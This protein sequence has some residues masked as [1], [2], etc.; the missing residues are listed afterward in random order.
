M[1]R[2]RKKPVLSAIDWQ[3]LLDCGCRVVTRKKFAPHC[4]PC[5]EHGRQWVMTYHDP[6]RGHDVVVNG[7]EVRTLE[8]DHGRMSIRFAH[9]PKL[10]GDVWVACSADTNLKVYWVKDKTDRGD[11]WY[12]ERF[13]KDPRVRLRFRHRWEFPAVL[14][15]KEKHGDRYLAAFDEDQLLASSL[16][17]FLERATGTYRYYDAPDDLPAEPDFPES[18]DGVPGSLRAAAVKQW[19]LYRQRRFYGAQAQADWKLIEKA[20]AERDG[21]LALGVLYARADAQYEGFEVVPLE[22]PKVAS[23]KC[24]LPPLAALPRYPRQ[25]GPP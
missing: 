23:I 9:D 20:L 10:K 4:H 1:A 7:A 21:A 24:S 6:Y 3:M 25:L 14:V 17:I 11:A 12:V 16:A 13:S 19:K 2:H 18:L 15:M 5:E 22:Q 8:T